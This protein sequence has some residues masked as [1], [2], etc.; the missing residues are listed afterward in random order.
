[1]KSLIIRHHCTNQLPRRHCRYKF[2]GIAK[3]NQ[4]RGELIPHCVFAFSDTQMPGEGP[5]NH[6]WYARLRINVSVH[7]S[8]RALRDVL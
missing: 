8:V 3:D 5:M 2:S 1:M 4:G 7:E 6:S